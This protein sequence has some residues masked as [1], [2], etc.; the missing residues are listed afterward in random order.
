MQL[1]LVGALVERSLALHGR[2]AGPITHLSVEH[3]QQSGI[4][5]SLYALHCTSGCYVM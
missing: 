3:I 1:W 2:I 5:Q 4:C